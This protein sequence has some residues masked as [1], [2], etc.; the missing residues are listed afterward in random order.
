[1][2]LSLTGLLGYIIQMIVDEACKADFLKKWEIAR[3]ITEPDLK[4]STL[5]E[6]WAE[7]EAYLKDEMG[8][9]VDL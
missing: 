9:Q 3:L 2:S 4:F 5:G 7:L 8:L 6:L 1:M